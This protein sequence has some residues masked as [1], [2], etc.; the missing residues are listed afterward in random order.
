[1]TRD[2]YEVQAHWDDEARRWWAESTDIPGLVT[3]AATFDGLVERV[4]AVAPDV[5]AVN[6]GLSPDAD[7]PIHVAGE[8][9]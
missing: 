2:V 3:E 8:R 7:V 9:T 4:M 1:M 6:T 5:L